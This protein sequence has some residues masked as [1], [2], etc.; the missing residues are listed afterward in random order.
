MGPK[1]KEVLKEALELPPVER[2]GVV[3]RIISSLDAPDAQIDKV[4]RKE[5]GER[6]DAYRSGRMEMVSTDEVLAKYKRT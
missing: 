6:I 1:A 4:W 5:I 2:A 3:D